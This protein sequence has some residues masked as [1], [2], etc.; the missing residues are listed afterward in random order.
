VGHAVGLLHPGP[1]PG[2]GSIC[3][4]PGGGNCAEC[5]WTAW[6]ETDWPWPHGTLGN[7][8]FNVLD[9]TVYTPGTTE[10]D[11]HDFMSYGGPTKWVSSRNWIRLFNAFAGQS[12]PYPKSGTLSSAEMSGGPVAGAAAQTPRPYLLVSGEQASDGQWR[13]DPAYTLSFAAGTDD[14]AGDGP[15]SLTLLGDGGRELFV[16]RFTLEVGH[17]DT[18]DGSNTPAGL[19]FVELLPLPD[20]TTTLLLR[21]GETVLASVERSPAAPSVEILSPSPEG[22]SLPSATLLVRWASSD[23]DGDQLRHMVQYRAGDDGDWQTLATNLATNELDVDLRD[24]PGSAAARLRVLATDGLRTGSGVSSPF[25]VPGKA[26]R[27]RILLPTSPVTIQE[28][29][30]LVLEG[31]ASDL[32]DGLLEPAALAWLDGDR[33]LGTGRRLE[34]SDLPV[35]P[36]EITLRASD[37]HGQQDHAA[38]AVDVVARPNTQPVA[39]A[40]PELVVGGSCAPV[41]DGGASFDADGD[42][43]SFLWSIVEQPAGSQT[44]L[45]DAEGAATALLA[46]RAG[47]Y[48]A[49]LVV[50]D[51]QVASAAD[52][53]TVRLSA[54]ADRHCLHLPV[55]LR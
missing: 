22:I 54:A 24:L 10:N 36:H 51:G 38:I 28:G 16:R 26:P 50:Q 43:L 53:T 25:V 40:G 13:L 34:V 20:G 18:F 47:D 5:E 49:E 52:R 31:A 15:Y 8:G 42:R 7:F 23:A 30:R 12:L 19:S 6:C 33:L 35:G 2:H 32:E 29:D 21:Q 41:L 1:L 44:R 3:P 11:S 55:I 17:F 46:D 4:P 27:V 14:E 9:M 48:V 37:S 39:D 45:I